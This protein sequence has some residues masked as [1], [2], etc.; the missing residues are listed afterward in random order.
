MILYVYILYVYNFA[1]VENAFR[2]TTAIIYDR[3]PK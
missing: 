1:L 3:T 2:D